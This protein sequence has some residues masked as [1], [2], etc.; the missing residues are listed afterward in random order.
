MISAWITIVVLAVLCYF[1]TR[2]M[3][4]IPRGL[5]N[6]M[7]AGVE[8]LANFV[9]GVAGE[10]KGRKFFPIVATIFIFVFANAWL[11]LIPGFISIG[12]WHEIHGEEVLV[13]LFRGANTDL[14]VPLALA[15]ISFVFVEYWGIRYQ[16][17]LRYMKKF[18]NL[19]NLVGSAKQLARGKVKSSLGLL[20]NGAIDAF[21]GLVEGL[22]ELIRVV[23]FTFRLFGNMTAGEILLGSMMFLIPWVVAIPFY[24]L[25]LFVGF[26]QALIFSGL[27]LVFVVMAATSHEEH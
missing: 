8:A 4:L 7:E 1:A 20:V 23:S 26:V 17:F 25:E 6:V 27:T 15:L 5:Q 16:G 11:A 13:P 14:N 24:G 22:S 3:K 9:D 10:E 2:K 19:G 21:V 18:V 12:F